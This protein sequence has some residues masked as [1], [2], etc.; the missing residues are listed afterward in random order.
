MALELADVVARSEAFWR[1]LG[2][3]CINLVKRV[4]DSG[5]DFSGA[6]FPGYS[7]KYAERKAEGKVKRQ[8]SQRVSP[9]DL[10]L[11][12]DMM[13]DLRRLSV[14]KEGVVIGWAT[15]GDR[16]EWNAQMGRAVIDFD[17]NDPLPYVTQAVHDALAIDTEKKLKAWARKPLAV[18]FKV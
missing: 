18:N 13:Q 6:P 3:K 14:S 9:P 15:F 2:S 5:R 1:S 7:E 12:G 11:T 4:T 16:L 17:G 8:A 10:R